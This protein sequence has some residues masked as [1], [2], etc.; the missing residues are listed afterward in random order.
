MST[1]S[2]ARPTSEN[3][4][5]L[6]ARSLVALGSAGLVAFVAGA[7]WGA[8]AGVVAALVGL[9]AHALARASGEVER[10]LDEELDHR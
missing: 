9:A 1:T 2:A 5:P 7:A 4:L 8:V 6:L 3:R 10:I